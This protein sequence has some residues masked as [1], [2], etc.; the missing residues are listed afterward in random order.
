M[1][2][3]LDELVT[4]PQWVNE[5]AQVFD[6]EEL[7]FEYER[8][9]DDIQAW[10][11]GLHDAQVRFKPSAHEFSIAEVV[12][13]NAFSD[14]LS[15]NWIKLLAYGRGSEIDASRLISGDGARNDLLPAALEALTEA[16]RTLARGVIDALPE[17]C[18]LT[19]TAPHPRFGA[20][21]AKGWF[22]YLCVHRGIH[23]R[24]CE[25]VID[26]PNFP[27]SEGMQSQPR[28][29]YRASE[30]KTW[31]AETSRERRAR[32]KSQEAK[33]KAHSE[34]RVAKKV[35]RKP[36][37]KAARQRSASKQPVGKPNTAARK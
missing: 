6:W 21:N 30:R 33:P 32:R 23:L 16:C 17:R 18:D 29:A 15:W 26:A 4:N 2:L 24:Q 8:A 3:P 13:H 19:M 22:Y 31:L 37:S 34:K 10:L 5:R 12:T 1:T 27:R 36:G 14:E 11:R 7:L 25:Q 9:L 28:D 20:L 35:K